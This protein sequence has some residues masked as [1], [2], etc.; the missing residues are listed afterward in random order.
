[1]IL[2]MPMTQTPTLRANDNETSSPREFSLE[3]DEG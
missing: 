3:G 1:M 2:L